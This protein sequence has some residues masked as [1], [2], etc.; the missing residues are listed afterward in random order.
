[1]E[2][3]PTQGICKESSLAT[4]LHT[5]Y[6]CPFCHTDLINQEDVIE[7]MKICSVTDPEVNLSFV[8]G[9]L[10]SCIIRLNNFNN[11][12]ELTGHINISS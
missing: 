5:N 3:F 11:N 12:E 6:P 10:G 4:G 7:H 1:M 9:R 2:I 8:P